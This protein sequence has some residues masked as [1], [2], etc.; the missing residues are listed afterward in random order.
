MI[1]RR[2]GRKLKRT[3][4]HRKATLANLSVS[5]IKHKKIKTT[6]AKAKELRRF[7]ESL[8][9]KS[10]KAYVTKD[11]KAAYGV[12]LRREANKFLQDKGAI[13]TLFE[14][15]APKVLDRPGGYTRVLK[16]GRRL[17]DAAEIALIEL[18]DYNMEQADN[19]G[20][21]K[22]AEG[23]TKKETKKPAKKTKKPAV[24]EASAK[25]VKKKKAKTEAK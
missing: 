14:E 1:H 2:K 7:V 24:K 22:A 5:L 13:T 9:T 20:K 16:M 21:D 25:P 17:G 10:K 11:T 4:S 6:L 12:H 19:K 8:I 23:E 3:A 15:I 18:V